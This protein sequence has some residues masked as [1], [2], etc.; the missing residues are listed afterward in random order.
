MVADF[1]QSSSSAGIRV[2]RI[3]AKQAGTAF[4]FEHNAL[5]IR[6]LLAGNGVLIAEGAESLA[7]TWN[8]T[9][10]VADFSLSATMRVLILDNRSSL[11]KFSSWPAGGAKIA[12]RTQSTQGGCAQGPSTH[13]H[14][15]FP[16][17]RRRYYRSCRRLVWSFPSGCVLSC[18]PPTVVWDALSTG[19]K[20]N[21]PLTLPRVWLRL[22]LRNR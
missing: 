9:L 14:P 12:I 3:H 17:G 19:Q 18:Y 8:G 13:A 22:L 4:C 2:T 15:R 21:K 6:N 5:M 16:P 1:R 11:Q 10:A 7:E 20:E